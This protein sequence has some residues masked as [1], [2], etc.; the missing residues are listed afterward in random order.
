M[1]IPVSPS[2]T[3]GEDA[4]SRKRRHV[5]KSRIAAATA[6]AALCGVGFLAVG[7]S[8]GVSNDNTQASGSTLRVG[9]VFTIDSLNPFV[10]VESTSLAVFKYI[11]P[12]LVQ[13]NTKLKFV[14]SFARSWKSSGNGLTWTFKLAPGARWSDGQP[15]TAQDV[16]WTGSTTLKY[17]AGGAA[18]MAT[19]LPG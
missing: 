12:T 11:Y 1:R 9:V 3:I 4:V 2:D 8:A 14:P 17:A 13:Y 19:Y 7:A 18:Q 10:A 6:I 16:A 15:M 5:V